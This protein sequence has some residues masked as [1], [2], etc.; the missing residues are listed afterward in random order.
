MN[1]HTLGFRPL[2]QNYKQIPPLECTHQDF[3]LGFR[4]L[5]QN[6]KLIPPLECTHQEFSLEWSHFGFWSTGS[7]L[8]TNTGHH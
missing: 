1:G 4:P 8:Q 7:E 3:T 6:Y 5:V 2:V